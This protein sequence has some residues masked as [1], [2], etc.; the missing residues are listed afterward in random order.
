MLTDYKRA[1]PLAE[2]WRRLATTAQALGT[3]LLDGLYPPSCAHCER[4]LQHSEDGVCTACLARL[5][6]S[7]DAG[8]DA[9]T[10]QRLAPYVPHGLAAAGWTFEQGNAVQHLVHR[11]KYARDPLLGRALGERF[12]ARLCGSPF[13][14]AD[15]VLVPVPLHAAKLRRRG[16]NQAAWFAYGLGRALGLPVAPTLLER[17]RNTS[18]QTGL[19][20]AQRQANVAEVFRLRPG[21]VVPACVWVVDDV[22]TTGAT[23]GAAVAALHRA[24][25]P[26]VGVLALAVVVD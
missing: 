11:V 5:P 22:V 1:K 17:V 25:V 13:H 16:I 6:L 2:A 20:R 9:L 7:F 15:A 18:S 3:S 21:A 23:V 4:P 12:G 24:G 26:T 19:D 10:A 8:S 14:R